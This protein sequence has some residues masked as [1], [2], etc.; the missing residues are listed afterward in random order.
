MRYPQKTTRPQ[1]S[2]TQRAPLE[3]RPNPNTRT[4][5]AT[6]EPPDSPPSSSNSEQSDS[7]QPDSPNRRQR[8]NRGDP[9]PPRPPNQDQ[10][11]NLAEIDVDQQEL[12]VELAN[13]IEQTREMSLEERPRLIKIRESKRF[14]ELLKKVNTGLTRITP[15][16]STLTE[17]NHTNYGAAWYVQSKL[18]PEHTQGSRDA[19][20]RNRN[21]VP[22][23]KRELQTRIERL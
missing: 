7:E 3:E 17:I 13:K 20:R 6:P 1:T 11:N 5:T 23:W 4:R 14:K 22:T 19:S 2:N 10:N 18:A 12:E 15:I 9:T 16:D 21:K 8:R